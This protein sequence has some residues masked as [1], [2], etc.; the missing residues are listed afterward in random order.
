VIEQKPEAKA[1]KGRILI[2]EDEPAFV[3]AIRFHLQRE[4]YDVRVAGDGNTALSSARRIQPNLVLLDILLPG[5]DG[6]E[7][8]R[9][10]RQETNVP[11]IMLTA[12]TGTADK[13]VGLELGADDYI[14]K[15]LQMRELTARIKAA[16]RRAH[17]SPPEGQTSSLIVGDLRIDAGRH[18]VFIGKKEV[19]L[20]A[21]EFD[22]LSFLAQH[23]GQ[24][25][26][27]EQ[28]MLHVWGIADPEDSRTVDVHVRWLRE[29]IEENPS[30]PKYLLTVRNVGYRLGN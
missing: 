14:T 13:V 26:S 1:S 25:L 19:A 22:L 15:P 9:R 16:L 6:L 21:K 2:V 8:C 3:E 4:G 20:R 28:I 11:I 5:M 23:P 24:V 12:K 7:V 27:R 29:K 17:M 10:L 18:S 30:Q